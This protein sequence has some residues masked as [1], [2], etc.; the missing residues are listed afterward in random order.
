MGPTRTF[1]AT[2][3]GESSSKGAAE[4]SKGKRKHRPPQKDESTLPGVQKI[5]SSLRQT[6]RLLAKVRFLCK[7]GIPSDM[8]ERIISQ[9]M[10]EL[11]QSDV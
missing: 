8:S 6:R 10:S 5:K 1:K 11:K 7:V 4:T 2:P 3:Q 9:Q